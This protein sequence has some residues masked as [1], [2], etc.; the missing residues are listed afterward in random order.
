MIVVISQRSDQVNLGCYD[1]VVLKV[2]ENYSF[3]LIAAALVCNL[4]ILSKVKFTRRGKLTG[5]HTK[6]ALGSWFSRS[7]VSLTDSQLP[8][9]NRTF[10][11]RPEL[12][13]GVTI[14][15]YII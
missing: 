13:P 9:A 2:I 11:T 7:S 14:S 8:L 12:F 10:L 4:V 6:L 5:V 1:A 3:V 15:L